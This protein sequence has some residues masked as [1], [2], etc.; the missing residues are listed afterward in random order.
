MAHLVNFFGS[1]LNL[2]WYKLRRFAL[3]ILYLNIDNYYSK[4]SSLLIVVGA[5]SLS[6]IVVINA[7]KGKLVSNITVPKYGP[8]LNSFEELASSNSFRMIAKK[9]AGVTDIFLVIYIESQ[10]NLSQLTVAV[11]FYFLFFWFRIPNQGHFEFLVIIYVIILRIF[12]LPQM[13][14]WRCLE[15]DVVSPRW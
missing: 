15:Q 2:N 4:N 14:W 10:Q 5:L 8:I 1:R 13:R 3:I 9:G 12:I 6:A 7:Y 11:N